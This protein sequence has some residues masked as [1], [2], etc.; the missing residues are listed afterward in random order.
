MRLDL[1]VA[2][3]DLSATRLVES[4]LR[5]PDEDEA[6][7]EIERFGLSSNNITYALT[8][9]TLRY[10][11]F[12]PAEPGWGRVP[13]WGFARVVA[14]ATDGL[15]EGTR[16]FGFLPMATH[17]VVRPARIDGAGFVDAADHRRALAPAYNLYRA[18]ATDPGYRADREDEQILLRPLFFLAFVLDDFI[19]EHAAFG[20]DTIVISSASSKAAL[21]T[22]FLLARR[23]LTVI[24]LTSP[25]R[26]ET[27]ERLGVYDRVAAYDALDGLEPADVVFLDLAGD[28]QVR[29]AVHHR[30]G[31][32]LRHSAAVGATHGDR[33]PGSDGGARLPGASPASFFAPDRIR[34]RARQ[35]GRDGLDARLAES[36]NAF[37]AWCSTWLEIERGDGPDAVESA[38]RAV[39]DGRTRPTTGHVLSLR[40]AA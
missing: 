6:L 37:V 2:R 11:D 29:G 31:D 15:E 28:E 27:L 7:L 26:A 8:G 25:R 5:D 9:S 30:Y 35:W 34:L 1:E 22:A 10:W 32:R 38:Y 40:S 23:E 20:A 12:F 21:G 4:P 14:G 36:W 19:A 39:L 33:R 17:L 16:V 24:G 18:A 3:D 13:V